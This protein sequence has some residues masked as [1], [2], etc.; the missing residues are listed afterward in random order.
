MAILHNVR[1]VAVIVLAAMSL[2]ACFLLVVLILELRSLVRLIRQEGR[3]ILVSA[4]ETMGTVQG[5]ANFV[6]ERFVA[7]LIRATSF[8]TGVRTA[9]RFLAGWPWRPRGR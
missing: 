2:V 6:S 5:T 7:P 8:L 3:G 1:D 9:L 4:R